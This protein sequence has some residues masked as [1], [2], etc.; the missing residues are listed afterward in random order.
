MFVPF[1]EALY[2]AKFL[3]R[4]NRFI[5]ICQLEHN[6]EKITVHLQ[7]PGRLRDL[8]IPNNTIYVSYHD[9][10][11]RKTKCNAGLIKSPHRDILV[12]LN[13][14]LVNDVVKEALKKKMITYYAHWNYIRH[15]FTYGRS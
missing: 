14:T 10:S 9:V 12:S 13:S 2:K 5:L 3:S 11:N 15:E 6:Q 1:K 7:D 4:E 8:L